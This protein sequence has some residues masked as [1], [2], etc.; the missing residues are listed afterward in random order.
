[1]KK[2]LYKLIS[3][4]TTTT[5]L[6]FSATSTV[7][8]QGTSA[9]NKGV[10]TIEPKSLGGLPTDINQIIAA[11]VQLAYA[12]AGLVFF[13]ML[14]L[15][16]LR[17]LTAGGDEK[18]TAAARGTLTNAF[19]GLVIVVAAFLITQLLFIVFKI[20]GIVKFG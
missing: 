16:G 7:L 14:I 19:V 3:L 8:A 15:G 18:S 20:Q 12:L 1:M 9:S 5:A 17:Y 4:V 11:L 13:F 2:P 6:L 10:G